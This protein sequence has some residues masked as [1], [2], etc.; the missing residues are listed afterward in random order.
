MFANTSCSV[1]NR[2]FGP[3]RAISLT[4]IPLEMPLATAAGMTARPA[5]SATIVSA[6]TMT[7]EFFTM[8]SFLLRYEP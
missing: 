8:F 6:M 7:A 5:I 3:P 1:T 2:S 4:G